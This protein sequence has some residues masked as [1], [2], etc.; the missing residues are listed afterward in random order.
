MRKD[1]PFRE[2]V[3]PLSKNH[4]RRLFTKNNR[5]QCHALPAYCVRSQ[6]TRQNGETMNTHPTPTAAAGAAKTLA[7]RIMRFQI[8]SLTTF[9]LSE[10][11]TTMRIGDTVLKS[12]Q[13][14]SDAKIVA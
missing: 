6:W 10:R 1:R 9:S 13:K 7:A 8:V 5:R 4:N 12:R 11:T 14:S 3:H 2:T